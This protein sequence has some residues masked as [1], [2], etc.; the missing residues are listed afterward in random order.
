MPHIQ[1]APIKWSEDD[2]HRALER[3]LRTGIK[4]QEAVEQRREIEAAHQAKMAREAK[5]F[6]SLGKYIGEMPAWEFFN[7]QNKYGHEEL[8][9]KEF[10]RYHQKKFKHLAGASV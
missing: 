3:E 4:L 10:H 6:S 7:L 2:Y 9:S 5:A 8:H 1:I